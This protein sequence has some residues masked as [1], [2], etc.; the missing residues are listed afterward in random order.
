MD[1]WLQKSDTWPTGPVDLRFDRDR[2]VWVSPPANQLVTLT[3]DRDIIN[4]DQVTPRQTGNA[5][6][7]YPSSV[8][9]SGGTFVS[10]NKVT[11]SNTYNNG[12]IQSGSTFLG[13]YDTQSGYYWPISVPQGRPFLRGYL[14]EE[15][16]Y[17]DNAVCAIYR[18]ASST[19]A[20]SSGSDNPTITGYDFCLQAGESLP[21]GTRV[22]LSYDSYVNRYYITTF[23][24]CPDEVA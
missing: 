7:T 22:G 15:L 21:L 14:T 24:R 6:V 17:D 10:N 16:T 4:T 20:P 18:T 23:D 2:G 8:Y 9:D 5:T 11:V 3:A 13:Y 19:G 1:N 12:I